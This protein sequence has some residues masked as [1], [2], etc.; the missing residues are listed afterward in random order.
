MQCAPPNQDGG[1]EQKLRKSFK[2][3]NEIISS[4][5]GESKCLSSHRSYCH[6]D[7]FIVKIIINEKRTYSGSNI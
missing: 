3:N 7:A 6:L 1:T 2:E 4:I 5:E